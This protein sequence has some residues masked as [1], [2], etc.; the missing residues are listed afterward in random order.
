MLP[1]RERVLIILGALLNLCFLQRVGSTQSGLFKRV[2][3]PM[4]PGNSN[5]KPG[6]KATV[7]NVHC[8]NEFASYASKD[9]K[10]VSCMDYGAKKYNCDLSQCHGGAQTDTPKSSP[11]NLQLYFENCQALGVAGTEKSTFLV[12][13]YSYLARNK[14]GHLVANGF[15]V[16]DSTESVHQFK[17]PWKDRTD[18]NNMRVWCD[19]CSELV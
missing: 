5:T 10:T 19:K 4:H 13:A 2:Y 18:R 3:D 1:A 7:K 8:G 16:G 9:S 14:D 15:A 6:P 17:C 11:I 12:Y